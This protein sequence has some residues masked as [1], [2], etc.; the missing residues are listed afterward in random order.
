V[1]APVL[2]VAL[3]ATGVIDAGA[4][5]AMQLADPVL[6]VDEPDARGVV[7]IGLARIAPDEQVVVPLPVR[8]IASG[9]TSG[10]SVAAFAGDRPWELS[11]ALPRRVDVG[12]RVDR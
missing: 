9:G 6:R 10:L 5:R 2:L 4:R 7:R 8:W 11:V 1:D 3:P 12:P